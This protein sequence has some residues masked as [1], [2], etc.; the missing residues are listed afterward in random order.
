MILDTFADFGEGLDCS[1]SA[2]TFLIGS[3]IDLGTG[4]TLR[5]I[6]NGEPIYLVILTDVEIITAGAA[7]T[8]NWSLASDS[9]AA[10]S[11]TTSTVH[12]TTPT[13]VTDG[14]DANDA[15]LK[16]GGLV[17]AGHLPAGDYERFLGILVTVATTTTT[18]GT[19]H[20]FLT[21]DISKWVAYN[22]SANIA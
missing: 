11:T 1:Q 4:N 19:V 9:T 8:I 17:Y 22:D 16:A 7:G 2:G 5:D 14:T 6:G 15:E 21:K 18:A 13:Y 12:L 10:I 3:Q 20:A